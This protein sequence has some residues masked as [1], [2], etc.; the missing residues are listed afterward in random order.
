[1][2]VDRHT[3]AGVRRIDGIR[4]LQLRCISVRERDRIDAEA[5]FTEEWSEGGEPG[6][7]GV[8]GGPQSVF[9]FCEKPYMNPLVF[10]SLPSFG[11][12]IVQPAASREF[13]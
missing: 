2:A 4:A 13:L 5:L 8:Y 6:M 11:N 12:A 10:P 9:R 7:A 1:V 3:P